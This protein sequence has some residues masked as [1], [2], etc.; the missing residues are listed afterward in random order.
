MSDRICLERRGRVS[1][2]TINRPQAMNAVDRAG[3]FALSAAFD[4][5]AADPDQW[6]AIV[7]GAGARAFCAGN[8]L[9]QQHAPGQAVVPQTGFGG[10]T[11]R[12]DL[13]KPVIAAVNGIA[14]GGGFE[15]ALACDMVVAAANA[16]FAL[17]EPMVGLAAMA[18]G[19]LRLPRHVGPKLAAELV[20]TARRLSAEEALALRLVNQ[21]VPEGQALE[22]AMA[23]AQTIL[24]ASPLAV[25]A[26]K[27][28]MARALDGD[29]RA[30]MQ[31]H[32]EY[33]E[34]VAMLQ[35][36][37]ASEGPRAFAERRAPVWQ[38]R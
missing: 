8:D 26:S 5:F 17:P 18:G 36:A 13:V 32:L 14:F 7:T 27:A 29:L 21:V 30:A 15:L 23:L 1:I 33:P 31:A 2:L 37:D 24:T 9:K 16:R 25:R 11:A 22:A 19:L 6:V 38:A 12:F 34:I 20:M 28:A 4:N 35:S 3:H 10:L